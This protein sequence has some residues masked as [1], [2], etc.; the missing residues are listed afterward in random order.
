MIGV[1]MNLTNLLALAI[2]SASS[3]SFANDLAKKTEVPSRSKD[4]DSKLVKV[5]ETKQNKKSK[6]KANEAAVKAEKKVKK[7]AD[8]KNEKNS[9][10]QIE[11]NTFKDKAKK[12]API[13]KEKGEKKALVNK[14]DEATKEKKNPIVTNKKLS[15]SKIETQNPVE[16][17][18]V[19]INEVKNPAET[20]NT[21]KILEPQII[22]K[23][24]KTYDFGKRIIN[25]KL[26]PVRLDKIDFDGGF[27]L[28]LRKNISVGVSL[29][30]KGL[31]SFADNENFSLSI[32]ER[33]HE[34]NELVKTRYLSASLV[35]TYYVDQMNTNNFYFRLM[36]SYGVLEGKLNQKVLGSS[37]ENFS[38]NKG[39]SFARIYGFSPSVGYQWLWENGFNINLGFG[40]SIFKSEALEF[41]YTD[42]SESEEITVKRRYGNDIFPYANV[43]LGLML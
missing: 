26:S 39:N 17:N 19:I 20:K 7:K 6:T 18:Q 2:I 5:E 32:R 35:S 25:L 40:P 29:A 4:T 24:K 28:G 12:P 14:A 36:F 9:P 37:Y 13:L 16:I 8:K 34:Q 10:K 30:G 15:D 11:E 1:F 22:D 27:E 3:H 23:E 31:G 38:V 43:S 41:V 21:A 42:H 33:H